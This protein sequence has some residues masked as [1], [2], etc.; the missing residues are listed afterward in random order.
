MTIHEVWIQVPVD[1]TKDDL[2]T[3]LQNSGY[4]PNLPTFF[5]MEGLVMYLPE[6]SVR[7]TLTMIAEHSGPGSSVMLDYIF[8]AALDGRIESRV[9]RHP[10]SLKFIFNEPVVFGIEYGQA[11]RYLLSLGFTRA[12]DFTP[13]NLYNL[14]LKPAVPSRTISEVY[15][16]ATAYKD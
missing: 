2:L 15:A 11:A 7:E 6:S 9:T 10:T 1:F 3:C 4:D 8:A 16:F 5:T 12:E 14:I 13:E